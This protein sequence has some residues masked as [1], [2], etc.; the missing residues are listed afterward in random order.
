MSASLVDD[1]HFSIF[2]RRAMLWLLR[3]R[4]CS[5]LDAYFPGCFP[6]VQ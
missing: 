5:M 3:K 2:S 4:L 1:L 6:Y